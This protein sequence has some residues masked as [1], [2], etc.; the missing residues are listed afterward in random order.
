MNA[1][2][3]SELDFDFWSEAGAGTEVQLTVPADVAFQTTGDDVGSRLLRKVRS[4]AEHCHNLI[5]ILTVDD[6]PLLRKGIAA[7]VN[8][9]QDLKLVAEASNGKEALEAFRSHRPDITLMDLQMPVMDGLE[10]IEAIGESSP[11][12]GSS[13]SQHTQATP[14]CSGPLKVVLEGTYSKDTCTRSCSMRSVPSMQ[15]KNEFQQNLP[16]N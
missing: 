13:F 2:S 7:L 1:L 16:R 8:A 11:R 6:H 15:D 12:L 5:R 4:R 10:T 3:A 14:K 9:E